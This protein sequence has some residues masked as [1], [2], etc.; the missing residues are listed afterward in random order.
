MPTKRKAVAEKSPSFEHRT[1]S[2]KTRRA[3]LAGASTLRV[4]LRTCS[5]KGKMPEESGNVVC[6]ANE[7]V[8]VEAESLILCIMH[9]LKMFPRIDYNIALIYFKIEEVGFIMPIDVQQQALLILLSGHDYI[10]H[11]QVNLWS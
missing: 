4:S 6:N 1:S 7:D 11:A 2:R 9:K 10:L 3:D 5:K 8:K